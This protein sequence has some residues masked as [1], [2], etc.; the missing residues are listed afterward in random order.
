M[1]R[2]LTMKDAHDPP[3]SLN[4]GIPFDDENTHETGFCADASLHES[5]RLP[6][7]GSTKEPPLHAFPE[8][9]IVGFHPVEP[10]SPENLFPEEFL[11]GE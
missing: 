7:D 4:Q 6:Q 3:L 2:P 11:D 1:D 5:A 10:M 9:D 8:D